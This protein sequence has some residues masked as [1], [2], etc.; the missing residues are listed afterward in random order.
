MTEIE[1]GKN[2]LALI[3]VLAL[4]ILQCAAWTMGFN[5]Q[6]FAFTSAAIAG[7]FAWIFGFTIGYKK[8]GA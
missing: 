4:I 2:L 3:A 5:G 8:G 1:I 6:V 7:I